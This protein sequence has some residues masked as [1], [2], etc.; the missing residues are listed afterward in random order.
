MDLIAVVI[1]LLIAWLSAF[2]GLS[3]GGKISCGKY[4]P[5]STASYSAMYAG[6]IIGCYVLFPSIPFITE[7]VRL[8]FS[9]VAPGYAS[10]MSVSYLL[11]LIGFPIMVY[12]LF[13]NKKATCK[14]TA[15]EQ[16]VFLNK[17]KQE[18]REELLAS[19]KL[20]TEIS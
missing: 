4:N 17:L 14:P 9:R 1:M 18:R 10:Q 2:V 15:S 16:D 11:L 5:S 3:I 20:K 8:V 12:I 19:K 13:K 7:P 6:I